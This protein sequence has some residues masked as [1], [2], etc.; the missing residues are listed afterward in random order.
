MRSLT[1][2]LLMTL[3]HSAYA[4]VDP[5]CYFTVSPD[6]RQQTMMNLTEKGLTLATGSNEGMQPAKIR[7]DEEL[8]FLPAR[9]GAKSHVR[10]VRSTKRNV[11]EPMYVGTIGNQTVYILR[12]QVYWP[13]GEGH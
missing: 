10:Y 9:P 4:A 11:S 2:V 8:T 6:E 7:E 12:N 5:D 1:V 3:N 13:C